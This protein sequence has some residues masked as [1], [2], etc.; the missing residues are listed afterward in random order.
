VVLKNLFQLP[1]TKYRLWMIL[2]SLGLGTGGVFLGFSLVAA[3]SNAGTAISFP[4][5]FFVRSYGI[6]AF[7]IPLYFLYAA[8]VLADPEYRPKSIFNLACFII[9]FFT[10]SLGFFWIREFESLSMES[11]VIA[12]VGR[13]GIGF[14]VFLLLA[15]ELFF[16]A[17]LRRLLFSRTKGPAK[18]KQNKADLQQGPAAPARSKSLRDIYAPQKQSKTKRIFSKAPLLLQDQKA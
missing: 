11:P 1:Q 4:G 6:L 7:L 15:L 2:G 17:T 13:V 18:T 16:I 3:F 9:P 10:L 14:F 8:F 5:D 12:T